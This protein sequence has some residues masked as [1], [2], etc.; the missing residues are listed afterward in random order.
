[1]RQVEVPIHIPKT[2][3]L[4]ALGQYYAYDL[5]LRLTPGKHRLAG[6]LARRVW[7]ARPPIWAAISPPRPAKAAVH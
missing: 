5:S 3:V 2:Q 7:R 4:T 1:V 6:R